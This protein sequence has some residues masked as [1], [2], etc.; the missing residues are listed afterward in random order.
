MQILQETNPLRRMTVD[1]SDTCSHTYTTRTSETGF[2]HMYVPKECVNTTYTVEAR[3][4]TSFGIYS[5]RSRDFD[6]NVHVVEVGSA[7]VPGTSKWWGVTHFDALT[8]EFGFFSTFMVGLEVQEW[9]KPYLVGDA[10]VSGFPWLNFSFEAGELADADCGKTSCYGDQVIYVGSGP[11][12]K[13]E[14]DE[15][16]LTHEC[17]HWFQDMFMAKLNGNESSSPY[18][19]AGAFGEG[20]ASTMP[21]IMRGDVWTYTYLKGWADAG[22]IEFQGSFTEAGG[23]PDNWFPALPFD[24]Y[25]TENDKANGGW[26]GRIL[27]DFFDDSDIEPEREFARYDDDGS[28]DISVSNPTVVDYG[29]QFDDIGSASAF[30]DVIVRY[31]GGNYMPANSYRPSLDSRGSLGLDMTEFLDG[32]ICRGHYEWEDMEYIVFDMM[33]FNYDFTNA[34]SSCP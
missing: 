27:W 34:P 10:K 25:N 32:M 4:E 1:V 31:L 3:A 28:S 5:V 9:A 24:L 26:S 19:W 23:I 18:A 7:S 20:F 17:F 21:A 15:W 33:D 14:F 2:W 6:E 12:N 22:L 8:A 29:I 30:Q 13:D 16:A 11:D